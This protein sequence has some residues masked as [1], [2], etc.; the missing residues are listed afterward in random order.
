MIL[1]RSKAWD[2]VG[3]SSISHRLFLLLLDEAIDSASDYS[4]RPRTTNL[5]V[6][7]AEISALSHLVDEFAPAR[8]HLPHMIDEAD[9]CALRDPIVRE[10]FPHAA[11]VVRM[12]AAWKDNPAEAS[13]HARVALGYLV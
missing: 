5:P 4:F 2:S 3:I 6:V 7:L 11:D 12:L 8:L 9:E 10:D 1:H 13:G